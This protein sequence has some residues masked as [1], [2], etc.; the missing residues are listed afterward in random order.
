MMNEPQ[1]DL[2][3]GHLIGP[4]GTR[5]TEVTGWLDP[6]EVVD[7]KKAGA[8]LAIDE[9]AGWSWDVPLSS[10]TMR[11]VVTRV[12]SHRLAGPMYPDEVVMRPGLWMSEDGRQRLVVLSEENPW[13]RKHI[14]ELRGEYDHQDELAKFNS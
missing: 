5:W 3:Q 4:D 7:Y 1:Y 9:C 10:K 8:L 14:A 6:E 2:D 13:K 12:E 11:Q